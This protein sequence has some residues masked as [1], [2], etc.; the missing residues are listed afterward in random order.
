MQK[1][2]IRTITQFFS[3]CQSYSFQLFL[4]SEPRHEPKNVTLQAVTIRI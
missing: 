4:K 2:K 3:I 1:Y